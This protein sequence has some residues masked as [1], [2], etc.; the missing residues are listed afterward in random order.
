M[1]PIRAAD[2]WSPRNQNDRRLPNFT[3][4]QRRRHLRFPCASAVTDE[5][6]RE[7]GPQT[8]AGRSPTMTST[9]PTAPFYG[10]RDQPGRGTDAS[11]NGAEGQQEPAAAGQRFSRPV[12]PKVAPGDVGSRRGWRGPGT[13]PQSQRTADPI[14]IHGF[15][16]VPGKSPAPGTAAKNPR[17][18]P[19][20]SPG[21][22][23]T[24]T[25][26]WRCSCARWT[27]RSASSRTPAPTR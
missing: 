13:G 12:A 25:E 18:A 8:N 24:K 20:L 26:S 2:P 14:G 21:R 7:W 22:R 15:A 11:E 19:G 9:A 3:R 6:H 17:R 10:E 4:P 5:R 27:C 1:S 16:A 23:R